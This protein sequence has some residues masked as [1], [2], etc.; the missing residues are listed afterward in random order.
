MATWWRY[1][2]HNVTQKLTLTVS[3]VSIH[4]RQNFSTQ[5]V[6][7]HFSF[8][9]VGFQL[10]DSSPSGVGVI[11]GVII[12]AFAAVLCPWGTD[13]SGAAVLS[14]KAVMAQYR[15][16]R[17][18]CVIFHIVPQ[19][20]W[21]LMRKAPLWFT[22]SRGFADGARNCTSAIDGTQDP[23]EAVFRPELASNFFLSLQVSLGM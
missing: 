14:R 3:F 9:L 10:S 13:E 15:I 17:N 8:I 11:N 20:I 23:S 12:Q 19:M 4:L 21:T 16:I 22:Y 18:T 1:A 7:M 6:P 5:N 2:T